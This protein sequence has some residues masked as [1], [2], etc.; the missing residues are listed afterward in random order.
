VFDLRFGDAAKR[1]IGG[2][3]PAPHVVVVP[4]GRHR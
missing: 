3:L 2:L 4:A 1:L